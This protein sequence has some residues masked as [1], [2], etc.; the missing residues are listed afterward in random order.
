MFP[1]HTHLQI[2][3][4]INGLDYLHQNKVVHGDL[5]GVSLPQAFGLY[6]VTFDQCLQANIL[7][8]S[9][10]VTRIADFGL[11][12]IFD[13]SGP[14]W[15]SMPTITQA[16]GTVRWMAPEL[17]DESHDGH[18]PRPTFS[19]D[20]YSLGSIMYEVSM[21]AFIFHRHLRSISVYL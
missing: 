5:K 16:G 18:S 2:L 9:T 4:V 21:V 8:S 19:S 12:S 20:I 7:V 17:L 1:N 10:G 13:T 6:D 15:R 14:R 3:D 11:S